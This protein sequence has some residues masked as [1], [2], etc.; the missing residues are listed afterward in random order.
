MT[1]LCEQVE[2]WRDQ[3]P[4]ASVKALCAAVQLPR[5]TFYAWSQRQRQSHRD[6]RRQAPGRA[7]RGYSVMQD[8]TKIPDGQIL[9]WIVEILETDNP[10]YGYHKITWVLR[11]RYRLVISFKKVYRLLKSMALLWPQ[12]RRKAPHPRRLARNWV[13]TRPNQLWETD[14][15]YGYI[16]GED[17]FFYLQA[18]LDVCDRQIIAYHIGLC[19]RAADTARTLAQAVNHRRPQWGAEPPVIRTD[20]GPQFTAHAFEARCEELELVH[21]RIPVA[22]PNMNAFIESWHAQLERECLAQEFTTFAEAYHAVSQW[23]QDYNGRRL[24]GSL[25]FWSPLEMAARV[26]AGLD[27]WTP[28]RA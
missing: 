11:R 7:P 12:W 13:V 20:N 22:T 16:A 23:I 2:A 17:R 5:G 24:H 18:I 28:V 4:H 19:C 3:A 10:Q 25:N 9:D 14:I 1:E 8:G 27:Q 6:G 26:A 21:E 15:T